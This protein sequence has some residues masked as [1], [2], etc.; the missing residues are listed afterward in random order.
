MPSLKQIAIYPI[1]SLDGFEL[2]SVTV[3][4]SGALAGDR[5]Y[6]LIDGDGKFLNGK[7]FAAIHRIR[8][9]YDDDLESV[10]LST[11]DDEKRFSLQNER[12]AIANWCGKILGV[13]CQLMENTD[14]GF[15]DDRDALGPTLISNST[16][17]EISSWFEGLEIEE[18]RRRLRANLEIEAEPAFWEDRLVSGTNQAK[19]FRVGKTSWLGCGISKRCAVPTRD[20]QDGTAIEGFAREFSRRRQQ[21]L[22]EW[23]PKER[24]DHFYRAAI[25]TSLESLED[26]NVI[27]IGDSVELT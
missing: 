19:Q 26:G 20:S 18:M 15:P 1:K 27:R 23:S 24:F 4:P 9:K 2:S 5:R 8:A 3:L 6:A 21:S 11:T 13:P 16:L 22:P 7:R 14:N 25:N 17:A 12:D 10:T